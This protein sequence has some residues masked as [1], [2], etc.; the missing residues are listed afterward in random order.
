MKR[1]KRIDPWIM[2]SVLILA[3]YLLF[4]IYPMLNV[5]GRSVVEDGKITFKYFVTFFSQDYYI[6]T[7]WNSFKVSI[8]TTAV[9]LI[10]GI[11]LAYFYNIYEIHGRKLLQTVIVLCTMSAPFIGA[12]AWILLLGNN[13]VI[14]A[15]LKTVFNIKIPSI[16]GF[17]GILLAMSTRLFPLAFM[18]VS[19]AMQNIDNIF[20]R[21]CAH[22]QRTIFHSPL[23]TSTILKFWRNLYETRINL[24]A[25]GAPHYGRLDKPCA[26]NGI[27]YDLGVRC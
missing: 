19:S 26:D 24:A 22:L 2:V 11:P 16:Y 20:T 10:L 7:L 6:S 18:Y 5:L 9:S 4:L 1:A 25:Q 15:F 13:G 8:A 12:Y 3:L 21:R 27:V 23:K 14:T 17:S